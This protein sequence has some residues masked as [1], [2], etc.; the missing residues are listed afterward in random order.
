MVEVDGP[1]GGYACASKEHKHHAGEADSVYRQQALQGK[2][3]N[4]LQSRGIYINQPDYFFYQGGSKTGV[5][6][7]HK[8]IK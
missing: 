8:T 5:Y 4:I 2:F 6:R 3:F 1:Y 7:V